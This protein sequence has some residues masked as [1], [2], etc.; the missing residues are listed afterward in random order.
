MNRVAHPIIGDREHGDGRHNV[1]FRDQLKI[2]GLCLWA[3]ELTL[4]HPVT[5]AK[6]TFVSP[7]P[8][9]WIE[10]EKLF[11]SDN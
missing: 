10:I 6:M 1:F 9:K 11:S 5:G 7:L 3:K 2:D 8:E 4:R